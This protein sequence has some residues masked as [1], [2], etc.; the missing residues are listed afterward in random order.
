MHE[1]VR[2]EVSSGVIFVSFRGDGNRVRGAQ[3]IQRVRDECR[4]REYD[5]R[6][7]TGCTGRYSSCCS[8]LS[9]SRGRGHNPSLKPGRS[10][11]LT[12]FY[13]RLRVW[14]EQRAKRRE[15]LRLY[16]LTARAERRLR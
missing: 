5:G 7:L 13:A 16:R 10:S 12:S 4:E 2:V 8:L 9:I 3:R 6:L 15:A 1:F 14:L 11:T